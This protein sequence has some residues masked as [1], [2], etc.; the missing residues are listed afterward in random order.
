MLGYSIIKVKFILISHNN[1]DYE[2]KTM[3]MNEKCLF[4]NAASNLDSLYK[5]FGI[6]LATEDCSN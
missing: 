1:K 3:S 5:E 6:A 2:T 4:T